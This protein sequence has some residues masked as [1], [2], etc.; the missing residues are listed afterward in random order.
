MKKAQL[1]VMGGE[2]VILI[3]GWRVK[4]LDE[5][6]DGQIW[7]ELEKTAPHVRVGI[8]L[9]ILGLETLVWEVGN[10]HERWC[11]PKN[12]IDS[13]MNSKFKSIDFVTMTRIVKSGGIIR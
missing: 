5:D 4:A 11:D 10:A 9:C 1:C 3:I 7:S 13:I 2:I 8:D 6:F 12:E